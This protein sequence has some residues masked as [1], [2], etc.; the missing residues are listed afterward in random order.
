M[1]E[2][3]PTA[4]QKAIIGADLSPLAV[5]ACPGSGKTATAVRRVAEVRRRLE[6][7]RNHVALLSYSNVAVET[8][9]REYKSLRGVDGDSD[10][11]VIQTVDSFITTFVLRPHGSRVMDC[12]RTPFLVLGGEPFL[13]SYRFG[14]EA[15]KLIGL[16]ELSLSRQGGQTVFYRRYKSGGVSP[17]DAANTKLARASIKKLAKTGGY[18]YATGRAWARVLLSQEP[19]LAAALAR[20]FPQIVIDEAQDIGSFESEILDILSGAGSTISLV[21]DFHQSIYG[22]NFATG[23][24]LRAFAKRVGV[25]SLPLTENRR[26]MPCIV[27]AANSLAGTTSNPCRDTVHRYSGAHYWRYDEQQLPQMMSAWITG[28]GAAG[29]SRQE[30]AVLCRGSA[31]L[32]RLTSES[33]DIGKSAVKHFAAAALEREQGGDISKVLDHCAKGVMSVVRDLPDSFIGDLK[34]MRDAPDVKV[35]RRLVWRLIRS[36][37]TGIPLA[38]QAAKAEWLPQLRSNLKTWLTEFEAK[39]PFTRE[40]TWEARVKST[41]LPDVGPLLAVDFGQNEWAGLRC[42]TVHSAKGEG[43][44]A[45]LYLTTKK[46]LDALVTGTTDEE[47]R[48]GFVAVTRARDLLVIGIPANTGKDVVDT[49][50][51]HGFVDWKPGQIEHAFRAPGSP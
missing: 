29:Y 16:D 2:F 14:T 43:I 31:L 51:Q 20:R 41:S 32:S 7:T 10:R 23:D 6:G 17:L 30:A 3:E 11:V 9:R 50:V 45:V 21:G 18:T 25:L 40:P 24:Y 34:G 4:E 49:L 37:A 46:D 44:P 12:E 38:T 39:L 19:R 28:I 36:P 13:S 33:S 47:G 5:I 26:S 8:F 22:F 48:I 15:K 35:M 27:S 1:D 42:G